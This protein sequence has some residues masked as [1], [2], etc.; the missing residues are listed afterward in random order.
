L[1]DPAIFA[2]DRLVPAFQIVARGDD[3]VLDENCGSLRRRWDHNNDSRKDADHHG[4][5]SVCTHLAPFYVVGWISQDQ[6]AMSQAT[7][8]PTGGA[9]GI[10][11]I[12]TLM[13]IE[14]APMP[15][16]PDAT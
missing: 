15:L 2:G 16:L 4:E 8:K 5:E 1:K 14:T 11:S 10:S 3:C 7:I 9:I 13:P 12:R 6:R